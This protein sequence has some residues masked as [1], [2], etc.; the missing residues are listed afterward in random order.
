MALVVSTLKA[1]LLSI[2]TE[3]RKKTEV[4]DDEIAGKLAAAFDKYIKTATVTVA[5]GIAVSTAG[6]PSAQTGATTAPGTGTIS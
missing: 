6:S 2:L 4:A 5:A 1:D 3:M